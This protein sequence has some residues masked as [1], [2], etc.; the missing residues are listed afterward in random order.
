MQRSNSNIHF[1]KTAAAAASF[2][3]LS[4]VSGMLS[5][6]FLIHST[7]ESRMRTC[8]PAAARTPHTKFGL[9]DKDDP[10]KGLRSLRLAARRTHGSRRQ[11]AS[12]SKLSSVEQV[13]CGDAPQWTVSG[14]ACLDTQL[15]CG[16]NWTLLSA[17]ENRQG[18]AAAGH[19]HSHIQ[20]F[21]N[22]DMAH[23]IPFS[24]WRAE[25]IT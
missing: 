15:S 4:F 6:R 2:G 7:T 24:G 19:S 21:R 25:S 20:H 8:N 3:E 10:P 11:A 5:H 23:K 1:P 18:L 22:T 12:A 14:T 13:A 17:L 16:C 9:E